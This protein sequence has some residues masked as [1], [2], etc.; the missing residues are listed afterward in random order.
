MHDLEMFVLWVQINMGSVQMYEFQE[1]LQ[2]K[3]V[4]KMLD[5]LET[6]NG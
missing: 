1:Q 3:T 6:K 4:A 2:A 5:N